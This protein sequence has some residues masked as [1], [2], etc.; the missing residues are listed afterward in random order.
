VE[1]LK[2]R[3]TGIARSFSEVY[4]VTVYHGIRYPITRYSVLQDKLA[5]CAFKQKILTREFLLL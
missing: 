2:L 1:K 4:C 3:A 5:Y